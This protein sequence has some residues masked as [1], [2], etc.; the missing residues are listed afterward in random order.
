[1]AVAEDPVD[2]PSVAGEERPCVGWGT[3]LCGGVSGEDV[4]VVEEGTGGV[5]DEVGWGEVVL[6]DLDH[7]C[8]YY[9]CRRFGLRVIGMNL[10]DIWM[11]I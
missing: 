1:M 2:G 11:V 9:W 5:R 7:G 4:L 6:V 3:F 10:F 8:L